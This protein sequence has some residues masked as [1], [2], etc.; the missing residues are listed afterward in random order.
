M[1]QR[2]EMMASVASG[3]DRQPGWACSLTIYSGGLGHQLQRGLGRVALH[4][5]PA[6]LVKAGIAGAPRRVEHEDRAQPRP[7]GTGILERAYQVAG[8]G[9]V[10]HGEAHESGRLGRRPAATLGKSRIQPASVLQMHLFTPYCWSTA[11]ASS[12]PR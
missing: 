3:A 2:S 6:L 9:L 11:Q 7:V 12:T 4:G 10:G 5:E 1:T 8:L